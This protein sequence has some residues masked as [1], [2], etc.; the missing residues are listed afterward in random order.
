MEQKTH[1]IF[2]TEA[3][4]FMLFSESFII[5]YKIYTK[6]ATKPKLCGRK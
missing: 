4:Q 1:C 5:Y 3:N 2:I 6:R